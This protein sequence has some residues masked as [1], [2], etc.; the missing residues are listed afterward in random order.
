MRRHLLAAAAF[1][2]LAFADPDWASGGQIQP[3]TIRDCILAAAAAYREPPAVLLILLNVEGG[4]LGAVS[5][6]TN[7]TV[8]IG[9]MQVNQTWIPAIAAHWQA[10][11][12]AALL[13]LRDNFC[14]NVEAGAWILRR[15]LDEANGD[16]WRGVG[17]YHSHDPAYRR[18]YLHSVLVQA[19]RLR[20]LARRADPTRTALA[21]G[22][23]AAG[24]VRSGG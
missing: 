10:S 17:Y 12:R 14:A 15:G 24:A 8:D 9:P 16:F 11:Q 23:I 6:N 3:A 7:G 13:A 19:L 4:T 1:A 20:A 18:S 22:S 2:L 21:N 5:Y